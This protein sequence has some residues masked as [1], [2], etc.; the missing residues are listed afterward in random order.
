M[1]VTSSGGDEVAERKNPFA[2]LQEWRVE[3]TA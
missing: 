1:K 2:G 3:K